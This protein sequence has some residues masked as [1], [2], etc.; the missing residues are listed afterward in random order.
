MGAAAKLIRDDDPARMLA[1]PAKRG[2]LLHLAEPDSAAG[3]ARKVG[4]PRQRVNYHLREMESAGLVRQVGERRKGNCTER[5][6]QATAATYLISPEVLGPLATDPANIRD[7]MSWAYLVA[8]A[9]RTIRELAVLRER[10]DEVG[11]PLPTLSLSTDVRFASPAALNA[12]SEELSTE[13]AK[14]AAK[15]GG[16]APGDGRLFRFLLGAYPAITKTEEEHAAEAAKARAQPTDP[17]P[18]GDGDVS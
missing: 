3:V 8:L 15:H 1:D 17:Q 18:S 10:A 11:K 4:L 13:V 12:F 16:S 9:S 2:L 5:L 7:T 14:L 6:V